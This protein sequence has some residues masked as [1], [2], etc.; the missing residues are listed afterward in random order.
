M[1]SAFKIDED[2]DANIPDEEINDL[3]CDSK[4]QRL[5]TL[6]TAR[7]AGS[8]RSIISPG[9]GKSPSCRLSLVERR[10]AIN[11]SE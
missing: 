1:P 8:S 4:F 7:L 6:K 5:E 2:D 10:S 9:L 3:E 11:E